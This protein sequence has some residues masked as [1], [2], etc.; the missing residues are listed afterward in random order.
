MNVS[1]SV[2]SRT[3][4]SSPSSKAAYGLQVRSPFEVSAR[5]C[6]RQYMVPSSTGQ[7]SISAPRCGQAPGP[8]TS[9]PSASR[10][11][12]TSRPAMV[13]ATDS[14]A[15]TSAL[16]PATNQPPEFCAWDTARAAAIR[17]GLACRQDA[18]IRFSRGCGTR[19]I[20]IRDRTCSGSRP[21]RPVS[22]GRSSRRRNDMDVLSGV[23]EQ[24][25]AS[26]RTGQAAL[27]IRGPVTMIRPAVSAL[28]AVGTRARPLNTL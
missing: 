18:V 26:R 27:R 22:S 24:I 15:P 5:P 25:S 17:P 6:Q 7:A 2:A 13:R 3:Q 4:I 23:V 28:R 9:V 19:W 14:V 21:I 11:N 16:F 8:A 10:Q 20:G 12:T 1:P